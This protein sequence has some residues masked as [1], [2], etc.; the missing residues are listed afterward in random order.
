MTRHPRSPPTGFGAFAALGVTAGL[1]LGPV[2]CA[3]P[4]STPAPDPQTAARAAAP[5]PAPASPAGCTKAP[6]TDEVHKLRET[7]NPT[8]SDHQV[9]I[10][11]IFE[12]DLA[13]A[14]GTVAPRLSAVLV[15]F[16]PASKQ[17]RRETVIADSVVTIGRD[18]YCVV[19]IEE[20]TSQPG[21]ISIR[22]LAR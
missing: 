6:M 17:S 19:S 14:T 16:D 9:G 4:K 11:N 13:D 3:E 2:G 5:S 15:I 1:A 21:S 10:S 18:R 22:K 12:R 20:G 8:L 7:T